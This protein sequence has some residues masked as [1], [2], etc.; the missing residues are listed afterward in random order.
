MEAGNIKEKITGWLNEKL[1]AE[2]EY[3]FV[4]LKLQGRKLTVFI[5]GDNGINVGK[6]AEFSRHLEKNLDAEKL[7]GE[8]YILEV[9]SPGMDSPFKIIRQ[10]QRKIGREVSVVKF[11]GMRVDGI[12]KEANDEKIEVDQIIREK[13]MPDKT[14]THKI[15]LTEIKT[16]KLNF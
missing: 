9:S 2:P 7:L 16:T 13:G 10:Y 15:T 6:C 5:D 4:D 11:D 12:L 8:N 1:A 14:V 3:F